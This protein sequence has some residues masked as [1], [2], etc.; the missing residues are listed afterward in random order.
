MKV[1]LTNI[2]LENYAGTQLYIR[3]L[4]IALHRHGHDVEVYSPQIGAV[5]RKIRKAGVRVVDST[6]D[7]INVPDVIH[8]QHFIPA[9]DAILRFPGVPVIYFLHSRFY[10]GDIP[11]K[12]SQVVKYVAV[13]HNCLDRLIV[14][15]MIPGNNTT[16]IRNWV[17]TET[18]PLREDR[19]ATPLRAV[20]FSNYA[21]SDNYYKI[22]RAACLKA[23][24]EVDGIGYYLN[25]VETAPEKVIGRYDI[26]FA[27]A[28][29][30]MEAMAT[31]AAVIV[32]DANGLAETVTTSNFD[33][34]RKLN[35][36]AKTLSRPV[37]VSS[38][39]A[40]IKKYDLTENLRVAHRIREEASFDRTFK[41][42]FELYGEA[43]A[44][45]ASGVGQNK[46]SDGRTLAFHS[47]FRQRHMSRL[48][49]RGRLEKLKDAV[50]DFD[51]D[52]SGGM[53]TGVIKPAYHRV[54]NIIGSLSDR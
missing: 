31:G 24:L 6:R 41:T 49:I 54:F 17:D 25:K 14:T 1:L 46:T 39:I 13:D 27:K 34:F 4:A 3:D 28:K 37:E 21:K 5:A 2:W 11:P 9:V 22:V 47:R 18:F 7:L 8:A 38:L 32:C 53:I 30:A 44:E 26:V 36:G 35:F 33:Y 48:R 12:H 45:Y 43:I 16:V 15:N 52:F 50:K 29:A 10:I 20:V 40:E 19:P 42:I 23:G 51:A